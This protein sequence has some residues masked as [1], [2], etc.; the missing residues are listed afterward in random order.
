VSPETHDTDPLWPEVYEI[1]PTKVNPLFG[2]TYSAVEDEALRIVRTRR[3]V[4]EVH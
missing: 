1:P 2:W 3:D 4:L